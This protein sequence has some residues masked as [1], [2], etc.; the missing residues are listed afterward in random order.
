MH[1]FVDG[2]RWAVD[3]RQQPRVAARAPAELLEYGPT[4]VV[5][6][7]G[8]AQVPDGERHNVFPVWVRGQSLISFVVIDFVVILDSGSLVDFVHG[9]SPDW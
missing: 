5:A 4:L 9:A 6:L 8:D 7:E 3:G 1:Y 2:R